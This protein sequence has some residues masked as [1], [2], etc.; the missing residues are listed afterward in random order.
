MIKNVILFFS[1]FTTVVSFS[2][3]NELFDKATTA[4]NAGE[5]KEAISFYNQ[6]LENGKHSTALYFNLGNAYYKQNQIAESIYYY[7]KAL[8]LSPND[9]EI[10]TNL[11]YA[12]NM[13]LDAIDTLPQTKL[14]KLYKNIT[15]KLTFDQWAYLA[16]GAM[17]L[18]VFLYI[19]FY[20]NQ[21]SSRKRWAFIG[22]LIALFIC[23]VAI[24]FAYIQKSDFDAHQPAI[25]FAE[26]S[27]IK[28][29]PNTSS[30]QVFILHQGTKVNVVEQLND[31]CKIQLSDGKTGWVLQNDLK[32]LKEF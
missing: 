1:L 16:I 7:E 18:F 10:K 31:W 20:F 8:L 28:S 6:I 3:N 4:Y 25:L 13:T 5:F 11:S 17:I 32:L 24:L 9:T 15:S 27:M 29:E 26:E 22:S 14:S 21:Y 2:Q 12:Q 19:A 23:I 30:N